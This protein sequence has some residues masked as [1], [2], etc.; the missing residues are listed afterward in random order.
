MEIRKKQET[1]TE[2]WMKSKI[3]INEDKERIEKNGS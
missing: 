1:Q 2:Q 3:S